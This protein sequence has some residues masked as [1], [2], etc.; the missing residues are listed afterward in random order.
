MGK[1]SIVVACLTVM[2]LVASSVSQSD[3]AGP[4]ESDLSQPLTAPMTEPKG[5]EVNRDPNTPYD[6]G[7]GPTAYDA[8]APGDRAV[9]D[10]LISEEDQRARSLAVYN[11]LAVEQAPHVRALFALEQLGVG[12]L[13]DVGVVDGE[14]GDDQ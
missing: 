5:P 12:S 1:L 8:L 14:A 13:G 2:I 4:D 7:P 3:P 9:V 11:A 10:K 6:E